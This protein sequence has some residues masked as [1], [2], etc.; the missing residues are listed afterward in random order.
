MAQATESLSASASS[1]IQDVFLNHA[2]REHL[3]VTMPLVD[4]RRCDA[5]IKPFDRFAVVV[6]V[7]GCEHV[8]CKHAIGTITTATSVAN[9][10]PSPGP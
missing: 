1:N 2:R 5:R 8:V 3:A 7:D 4:G 6:D 9:H 10:F